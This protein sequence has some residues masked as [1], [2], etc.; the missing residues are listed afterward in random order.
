MSFLYTSF[1]N[2]PSC[3]ELLFALVVTFSVDGLMIVVLFLGDRF[4]FSF[5]CLHGE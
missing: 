4:L 1:Q 3:S 5:F 2:Q